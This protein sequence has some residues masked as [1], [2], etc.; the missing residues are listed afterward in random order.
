MEHAY[1]GRWCNGSAW[2][3]KVG[4]MQMWHSRSL[5]TSNSVTERL[6]SPSPPSLFRD[7]YFPE[8]IFSANP[9]VMME[10]RVVIADWRTGKRNFIRNFCV[11]GWC[12][13]GFFPEGFVPVGFFRWVFPRRGIMQGPLPSPNNCVIVLAHQQLLYIGFVSCSSLFCF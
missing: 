8:F 13:V 9:R 12:F 5:C 2:V 11:A 7:V 4:V 6:F 3:Y 10:C 1:C